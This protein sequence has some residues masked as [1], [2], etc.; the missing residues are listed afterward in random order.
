MR[1]TE[2]RI[3]LPFKSTSPSYIDGRFLLSSVVLVL[4]IAAVS[5]Y[6][7]FPSP[8][9]P[10]KHKPAPKV[11]QSTSLHRNEE[12]AIKEK[13]VEY[14][15]AMLL[16]EPNNHEAL[17]T[18]NFAKNND[19][20]GKFIPKATSVQIGQPAIS[21]TSP[22]DARVRFT[23]MI[24][25][26]KN[27]QHSQERLLLKRLPAIGWKIDKRASQP[28]MNSIS[29]MQNLSQDYQSFLYIKSEQEKQ[30]DT[31]KIEELIQF[32]ADARAEADIEGVVTTYRRDI[33]EKRGLTKEQWLEEF[34]EPKKVTITNVNVVFPGQNL[35]EV[36]LNEKLEDSNKHAYFDIRLIL[37]L[38]DNG[39]LIADEHSKML[40]EQILQP[41][42][43]PA[44]EGIPKAEPVAEPRPIPSTAEIAKAEPTTA[45]KMFSG[46][47][48]DAPDAVNSKVLATTAIKNLVSK[49]SKAW[50]SKDVDAYLGFY[51]ENFAPKSGMNVEQWR[52]YR[53]AR[54][55]K[56]TAIEIRINNLKIDKHSEAAAFV[57]FI[58]E[59]K[60]DLYQDKTRKTLSLRH[61][62]DRWKIVAEKATS[63]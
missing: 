61:E 48:I 4:A 11:P 14:V 33:W 8:T 7:F 46:S 9:A 16:E 40:L 26:S 63:L 44:L 38:T 31:E 13:L 55:S 62:D 24:R 10:G 34:R 17:F 36:T 32:W 25:T 18:S 29:H 60:S 59:Y 43:P 12:S 22:N 49:W 15:H 41:L 37:L 53:R 5:L 47:A 19:G 45:S 6:L 20:D 3:Y 56:P 27:W 2:A 58:Q 52:R 21:I 30:N 28:V 23:Q 39:W 57:S 1:S 42:V 54:L 50:S 51:S 35:A